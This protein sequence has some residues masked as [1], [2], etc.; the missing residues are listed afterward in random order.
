MEADKSG[1]YGWPDDFVKMHDR[2][3]TDPASLAVQ[4]EFACSII[5]EGGVSKAGSSLLHGLF[6]IFYPV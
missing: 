2:A 3:P 1:P 6:I 5:E 4:G